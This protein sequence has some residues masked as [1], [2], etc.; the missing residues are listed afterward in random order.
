MSAAEGVDAVERLARD[1][2]LRMNPLVQVPYRSTHDTRRLAAVVGM[3][4]WDVA[5]RQY[6]EV[7]R[8]MAD[9]RGV[10][11]DRMGGA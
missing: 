10:L 4:G 7:R 8:M 6:P 3:R 11:A 2:A 9:L 5:E 1:V